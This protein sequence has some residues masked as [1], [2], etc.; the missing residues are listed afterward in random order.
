MGTRR[1]LTD[2]DYLLAAYNVCFTNVCWNGS[3]VENQIPES[4]VLDLQTVDPE[5]SWHI[6]LPVDIMVSFGEKQGRPKWVKKLSLSDIEQ[7]HLPQWTSPF[8]SIRHWMW[9]VPCCLQRELNSLTEWQAQGCRFHSLSALCKEIPG[10]SQQSKQEKREA[11]RSTEV[12]RH[13]K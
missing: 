1:I 5:G 10:T 13:P 3:R 8:C 6:S 4:T 2:C 7:Q 11:F 12:I 9:Y